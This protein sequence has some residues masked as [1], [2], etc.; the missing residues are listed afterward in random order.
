MK[1]FDVIAGISECYFDV[2]D[3]AACEINVVKPAVKLIQLGITKSRE[4]WGKIGEKLT[5]LWTHS[6]TRITAFVTTFTHYEFSANSIRESV[7]LF[8]KVL[9][10]LVRFIDSS[11]SAWTEISSTGLSFA[12]GIIATTHLDIVEM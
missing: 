5:N 11:S 6:V 8:Q 4:W 10:L 2:S 7:V 9:S 1:N 12:S 3:T